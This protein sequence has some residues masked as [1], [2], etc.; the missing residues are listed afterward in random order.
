MFNN[1][2]KY[3]RSIS[4]ERLHDGVGVVETSTFHER[5]FIEQNPFIRHANCYVPQMQREI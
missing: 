5:F 2:N 4:F 1:L 3:W